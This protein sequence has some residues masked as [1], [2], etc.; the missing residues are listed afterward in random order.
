METWN[1]AYDSSKWS[2]YAGKFHHL[3]WP[4]AI[5]LVQCWDSP[6][7]DRFGTLW[8]MAEMQGFILQFVNEQ[9]EIWMSVCDHSVWGIAA[10]RKHF[11]PRYSTVL[12]WISY[13]R[14]RKGDIISLTLHPFVHLGIVCR[15]TLITM[16]PLMEEGENLVYTGEIQASRKNSNLWWMIQMYSHRFSH[17]TMPR[18]LTNPS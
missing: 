11:L 2:H 18:L 10:R 5:E 16:L 12:E 3:M 14:S 17:T 9:G 6:E 15:I 4:Q 1:H 7:L 13:V 8:V